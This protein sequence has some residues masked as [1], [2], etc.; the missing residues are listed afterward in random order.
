MRQA[1]CGGTVLYAVSKVSFLLLLNFTLPLLKAQV[2]PRISFFF[3]F[4][5]PT[6][7]LEAR[8]KSGTN[9]TGDM[10]RD[11]VESREGRERPTAE[12]EGEGKKGV[13]EEKLCLLVSHFENSATH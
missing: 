2:K 3:S 13:R 7:I 5:H 1:L 9:G 6:C 4:S 10:R 11:R 12:R 8:S